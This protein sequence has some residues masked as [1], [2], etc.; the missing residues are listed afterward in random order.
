MHQITLFQD[1]KSKHFLGR[2][3]AP[4]PDPTLSGEGDPLP[5]PHPSR[6][7]DACAFGASF[8]AEGRLVF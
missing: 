4:S 8:K 6:H 3:T 1:K 5:T 7:L 2:G